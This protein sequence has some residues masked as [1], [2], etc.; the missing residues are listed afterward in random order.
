LSIT[1]SPS[2]SIFSFA[3]IFIEF[4]LDKGR[5]SKPECSCVGIGNLN[6]LLFNLSS[7]FVNFGG[8]N[9]KTLGKLFH[10]FQAFSGISGVLPWSSS[11]S[12][13]TFP[14]MDE[15]IH[16]LV[17]LL[18]DL[19]VEHFLFSVWSVVREQFSSCL[20]LFIHDLLITL[21]L[22]LSDPSHSN[23]FALH[24]FGSPKDCFWHSSFKRSS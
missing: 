10:I 9:T 14:D 2:L 3:L 16:T 11:S 15:F 5:F 23:T 8:V 20:K 7:E 18:K 21:C 6:C 17:M 4:V 13:A 1:Y 12:A 22:Q 24:S 19:S